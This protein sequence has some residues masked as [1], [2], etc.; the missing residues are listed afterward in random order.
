ML[1]KQ[2]AEETREMYATRRK[3]DELGP[4]RRARRGK[5]LRDQIEERHERVEQ[6]EGELDQLNAKLRATRERALE[7]A[8]NQPRPKRNLAR[9]RNIER[10]RGLE[11]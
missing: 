2:R 8:R 1:E 6:L 3:L 9:G 11:R 4:L 7:L 10:G 5:A